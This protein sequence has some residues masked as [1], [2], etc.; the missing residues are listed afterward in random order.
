MHFVYR[1]MAFLGDESVWAAAASECA[2]EQGRFWDYHDLLFTYTAGRGRGVFT[3][4]NLKLYAAQLGLDE[5]SFASCV[6]SRRYEDWVGAQ[7]ELGR[8]RGVSSTPTL[9]VNGRR[10][11]PAPGW[12]DLRSLILGAR[13]TGS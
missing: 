7:T 1:H 8:Q 12:D 4:P 9:F 5:G 13:S 6:D 10:V 3:K 11:S 2:D